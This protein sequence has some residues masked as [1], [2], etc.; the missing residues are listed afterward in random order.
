MII[1]IHYLT[2]QVICPVFFLCHLLL[3]MSS[4][5]SLELKESCLTLK[6]LDKIGLK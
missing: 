2:G 3:I 1:M 4:L 6:G 5:E